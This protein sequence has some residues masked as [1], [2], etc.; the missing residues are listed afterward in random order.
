MSN[1]FTGF[2]RDTF[3]FLGDLKD[4]NNKQ[5]FDEN[6]DRYED[7][8]K[9]PALDFI[10][11]MEEVV[12]GLPLP[13]KAVAKVNGSLRRINRDVRFSKDKSP[14]NSDLHMVF[15][16]GDHPNRSS[17]IHLVLHPDGIGYGAGQ[18]AFSAEQ[19]DQYRRQV[20]KPAIRDELIDALAI[21]AKTGCEMGEPELKKIPREFEA[22]GE[23]QDFL[24][25]KSLVTRTYS[26]VDTPSAMFSPDAISWSA[27][28]FE[29]LAPLN[30]WI[31]QYVA[32]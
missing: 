14:Y 8:L 10:N 11:A 1:S 4:N 20:S 19:I 16:T 13:H 5:W 31:N 21:A 27:K 15:W 25:R 30:G 24:K 6:R 29:K 23:W 18:W 7:V 17:A 32:G 2:S 26:R 22:D 28:L 9:R 3:S 12:E